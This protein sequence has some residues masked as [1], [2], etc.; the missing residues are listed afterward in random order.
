L[1][2]RTHRDGLIAVAR[3]SIC[4][5]VHEFVLGTR[6]FYLGLCEYHD[7]FVLLNLGM[8]LSGFFDAGL[9]AS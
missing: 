6:A 2:I 7:C 9:H 8:Q 5:A 4:N 3:H 1:L